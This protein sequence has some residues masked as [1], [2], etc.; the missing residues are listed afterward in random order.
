M[1]GLRDIAKQL[2]D[3]IG[4]ES[5]RDV[6]S[7]TLRRGRLLFVAE[8]RLEDAELRLGELELEPIELFVQQADLPAV[9]NA[10]GIQLRSDADRFGRP[11][12]ERRFQPA[13]ARAQLL[14]RFVGPIRTCQRGHPTMISNV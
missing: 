10:E 1:N 12:C 8:P 7:L 6:D 5:R 13:G 14:Q 11:L 9:S 4:G 2:A 3:R